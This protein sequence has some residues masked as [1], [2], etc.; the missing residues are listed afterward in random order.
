MH[1]VFPYLRKRTY[2]REAGANDN[3]KRMCPFKG[4]VTSSAH[5]LRMS[6][7]LLWRL[8]E[9]FPFISSFSFSSIVCLWHCW[10]H[11][12]LFFQ[13]RLSP[14]IYFWIKILNKILKWLGER[15]VDAVRRKKTVASFQSIFVNIKKKPA[16]GWWWR[17]D[18][19]AVFPQMKKSFSSVFCIQGFL[20]GNSFLS[21]FSFWLFISSQTMQCN[22]CR[23]SNVRKSEQKE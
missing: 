21:L 8:T 11:E 2:W 23:L 19:D 1:S 15:D 20:I 17:H 12:F 7:H 14:K 18:F 22:C 3:V 9:S 6:F 13:I 4:G 5:G 10:L 16:W